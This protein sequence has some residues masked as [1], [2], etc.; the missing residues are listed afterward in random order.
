MMN[1]LP[2]LER[3]VFSAVRQNAVL[4]LTTRQ[5]IDVRNARQELPIYA[6]ELKEARRRFVLSQLEDGSL[7]PVDMEEHTIPHGPQVISRF[8]SSVAR[9]REMYCL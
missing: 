3:L 5:F 8:T 9:M 6:L 2:V 7:R 1:E 4:E